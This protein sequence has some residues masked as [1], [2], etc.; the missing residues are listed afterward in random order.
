MSPAKKNVRRKPNKPAPPR[1]RLTRA[2][3]ILLATGLVLLFPLFFVIKW[4]TEL[5]NYRELERIKLASNTKVFDRNLQ[6]LG[7]LPVTLP[8]GVRIDRNIVQLENISP[9]LSMAIITSEDRRFF[10]HYGVDFIGLARGLMKIVLGN[11]LEGGSTI[12]NQVI[13]NTL[14][15]ELSTGRTLERKYKEWILSVQVERYFSK[16]EILTDY[17]NLIYLGSGGYTDLI[18]VDMAARAYFG[19]SAKNLSLAESVYITSLIP[20]ARRYFDY[21]SYRPL[22]KNILTRMVEDGRITQQEADQAWKQ[23]L[24]PAGWQVRYDREGNLLDAKLV[25]REAKNLKPNRNTFASHFMQQLENQLKGLIPSS[26][27]TD[28]G[29]LKVFTTMDQQAQQAIE[30]ASRNARV[31]AGATMGAAIVDPYS[32][33]VRAMVGQKLDV[34]SREWNNAAQS[35][36]QVGSSIKPLLYATAIEN[37]Y[38]QYHT[39]LD[40]PVSFKCSGCPGGVYS[41]KNFS[42]TS[43]GRETTLRAALD[44]SLNLPTV[45]LADRIGID[46]FRNKLQ[47]LGFEVQGNEGLSLSIGTL[48]SNPLKM[49]LVYASFVNGGK[50]FQPNYVL[51]VE[52]SQGQVLYDAENHRSGGKQVWKQQTAFVMWDM[53]RGVVYDRTGGLARS[54]QIPG[55]LVGGKT[56]TTNDVKD[57]WFV[58]LTPELSGAVWVGKEEGGA[59]PENSYSGVIAAP[60]WRDMMAGAL[61]GKPNKNVPRPLGVAYE[62]HAGYQMAVVKNTTPPEEEN[63]QVET[64][65][66]KPE[67]KTD[68]TTVT[69]PKTETPDP[70]TADDG[71]MLVILDSVSGYLADAS[72]PQ[73][74]RVE[75]RIRKEDLDKFVK[76][77]EP[78]AVVTEEEATPPPSSTPETQPDATVEEVPL[79][80]STETT[81][82]SAVPVDPNEDP[83]VYPEDSGTQGLPS[84]QAAPGTDGTPADSSFQ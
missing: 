38:Q 70:A 56:G 16:D 80:E 2:Q 3:M 83:T 15:S 48:E 65:Q 35:K 6:Y 74:N 27:F 37:G 58:G 17:L 49:A 9:Y 67:E 36:R 21:P 43:S 18:G 73:Q 55:R 71:T 14:L 33:D 46:T 66:S 57:L 23:P 63:T 50:L 64:P 44:Q 45:R 26:A 28:P 79:G 59:M 29:G 76:P 41:P 82:P 54:A 11:R 61:R 68:Q 62:L 60:I 5:P 7:T 53:L 19:K 24:R 4:T 12:T 34:F 72:T 78:A 75:R 51:K 30:Q 52:N 84:G 81:D 40:A 13:K 42:M 20:N 47:D 32:G 8:T 25:N 31:P 22:M 39:E 69:A 10:Q 1:K 77:E